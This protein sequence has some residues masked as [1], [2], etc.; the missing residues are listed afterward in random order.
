LHL[1][2]SKRNEKRK[3]NIIK[4]EGK[5]NYWEEEKLRRMWKCKTKEI[6]RSG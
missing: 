1:G 5:K 3:D 2:S 6:L 4:S